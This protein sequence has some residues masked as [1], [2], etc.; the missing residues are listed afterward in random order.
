[1]SFQQIFFDVA[2]DITNGYPMLR[3]EFSDILRATLPIRSGNEGWIGVSPKGDQ[4][5]VVVPVDRQIAR[6]VMAC[7][8]PNDGTPFG[9]YSGWIY[10]ECTP[11]EDETGDAQ[12]KL[13]VDHARASADS[14][15]KWLAAYDIEA[16]VTDDGSVSRAS[17]GEPSSYSGKS[18]EPMGWR[19]AAAADRTMDEPERLLCD[20]CGKSWNKV[21]ELLRDSGVSMDRYRACL[22]DFR[23]GAYVFAH[24]CGGSVILPVN[25]VARPV[26]R[27][28]SLAGSHACP[29]LCRYEMVGRGC[30]AVCEGSVYLRIARKLKQR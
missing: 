3:I 24:S 7:N 20:K 26:H 9:G 8:R 19:P 1:M 27:G 5:H 16:E 15:V 18:H 21:S 10:F 11:Y 30:W 6:G 12:E 13:R 29:G 25:Q 17:D 28:R 14:L 23:R 4:Y 22:D 2:I